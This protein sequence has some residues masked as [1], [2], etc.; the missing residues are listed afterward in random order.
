[1]SEIQPTFLT[2]NLDERITVAHTLS[3]YLENQIGAL[4][5]SPTFDI[6][7]AYFNP[8]GFLGLKSALKRMG[9]TR[10]LLGAEPD[11]SPHVRPLYG[12]PIG[13]R[14]LSTRHK[15]EM[16]R[17]ASELRLERD[18]LGF[19]TQA[20]A[21]AHSLVDWLTAVSEDG[22]PLVEVRRLTTEFLHGKA[23]IFRGATGSAVFAGSSN[24]TYSGLHRNREL[25]L[26][27]YDPHTVKEVEQW[28][29]QMWED[30]EPFDLAGLY[31]ERW[32]PHDP[33]VI[34]GRMLWERYN[35][36][37]EEEKQD[38]GGSSLNLT[39]FQSDGAWRARRILEELHGVII[40]DEVGLGKTYLAG[41]LINQAIVERR[42]KVLI[43]A[44][45]TLRD[46]TWIPFL[47]EMNLQ[48]D[49]LSFDELVNH[50]DDAGE[51]GAR[52]QDLDDY[53][54]VVVDEAHGLRNPSSQRAEAMRRLVEGKSPKDLVLL[55]ATPV[56]NSL[57]DVYTLISYFVTN[58][59]QFAGAGVPSLQKYFRRAMDLH[60]DELS[61]E[62]LF[63]VLDQVAVRRTRQF[64]KNHY[65]ND[66]V[67]INGKKK[68]IFFPE[69][70]VNRVEYDLEASMP[71]LFDKVATALGARSEHEDKTDVI[72]AAPGE[73]LTMARYIPSRFEL[74]GGESATFERQN[75]GLLRSA[76]L[77][78]FESS[79][80]AYRKTLET[81]I[82]SHRQFLDALNQGWVLK[83]QALREWAAS[84][85]DDVQSFL[86]DNTYEEDSRRS[87]SEF[88]VEQLE[89][90][91]QADLALLK[92]LHAQAQDLEK[93]PDT[94]INAL[95]EQLAFIAA[96]A[97]EEGHT[98]AER[99]DKRKVIIFTYFA[100]TAHH[101]EE[102][103]RKR[104]VSD[105]RLSPYRDRILTVTGGNSSQRSS[106]IASF[107]P[108]TAGTDKDEDLYDIV[109]A[110]DVLA[111]G[112]N[113][114]QAR[115]IINYDLPWNPMR[116]VQ[117][118]GRIDRIGS[119]HTTVYMR[120]FFPDSHL[121][122][123]LGLEQRIQDKIKTANASFGVGAGVLPEFRGREGT[124]TETRT[125]ID[126]LRRE[127]AALFRS[128]GGAAA[129]SG[130]DYRR[131]LE[132]MLEDPLRRAEIEGLAWG[133]GSGYRRDSNT[134]GIV[135]CIRIADR[136]DPWFRYVPLHPESLQPLQEINDAGVS[137][138][139]VIDDALSCLA[140]ADPG[141]AE[142]ALSEGMEQAAY[143]AWDLARRDVREKWNFLTDPQN[144]RAEIP[145][146][147]RDAADLVRSQ[148][149]FLG[150]EQ[151]DIT[152]R[153]NAPHTKRVQDSVRRIV[154]S[155]TG[156]DEKVR[157]L[158]DLVRRSNLTKAKAAEPLP[159]IDEDDIH[160]ICWMA[161]Q[162]ADQPE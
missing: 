124:F 73:V 35:R 22:A 125:Q 45:A 86:T 160:L 138:P 25:N 38:R 140:Q 145:R 51:T 158:V 94:K 55:T 60:P 119:P 104:I 90:L 144:V 85:S 146:V 59:A 77:K 89:L 62:H 12:R 80:V 17:H 78:R 70:K 114:Q 135:F 24:F 87:A 74:S 161:F 108:R 4:R 32:K 46:S 71:G 162:P 109:V 42:Q 156:E 64:V 3:A 153:L 58:D 68:T 100:D 84:D 76:L 142:H 106:S 65:A 75:A 31:A 118:H 130:E 129:L 110:T 63:D 20:D 10:L 23:Y 99:R 117:R 27:Q 93:L 149:A 52:L 56:N 136:P 7:T 141:E 33:R 155:D 83:G 61:P 34:F 101:I 6:A 28:F 137:V 143:A 30:A 133:S 139:T 102:E 111:E 96:Q 150:T 69:P 36:E 8:G 81:L 103:L 132:K 92:E 82:E 79:T 123:M 11:S 112:V 127:S 18:L 39:R 121:D 131:T 147:L 105:D 128:G 97:E 115:H 107:T 67:Y 15:A 14:R 98:E 159:M 13:R 154:R 19:S 9:K 157:A 148:G 53:A 48:S 113:L 2:N 54:M 5:E 95:C 50:I 37:L 88:D 16:E 57:Q 120:C 21:A 152:D 66:T 122:E 26:G 151:N 29:E 43:I 1:M 49:V 126:E 116:L 91:C 72:E 134:A 44:P 40:A 41:E 47:R